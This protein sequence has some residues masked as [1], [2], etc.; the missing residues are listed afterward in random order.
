MKMI[1]KSVQCE[2]GVECMRQLNKSMDVTG[3]MCRK[4]FGYVVPMPTGSTCKDGILSKV[5]ALNESKRVHFTNINTSMLI[6][7]YLQATKKLHKYKKLKKR[8]EETQ[9]LLLAM[10]LE[11]RKLKEQ[12]PHSESPTMQLVEIQPVQSNKYDTNGYHS[13][14]VSFPS[15]RRLGNPDDDDIF[16]RVQPPVLLGDTMNFARWKR[17]PIDEM[18]DASMDT[19]NQDNDVS[20]DDCADN[21]DD[22]FEYTTA[23]IKEEHELIIEDTIQIANELFYCNI[24]DES[25][26]SCDALDSHLNE[27]DSCKSA[28]EPET[29][30]AAMDAIEPPVQVVDVTQ[31]DISSVQFGNQ[32]AN[33]V[34]IADEN[35]I[36]TMTNLPQIR[37]SHDTNTSE[38]HRSPNRHIR[39]SFCSERDRSRS[40]QRHTEP[41]DARDGV[42]PERS[43]SW[44]RRSRFEK[45]RSPS[46][47]REYSAIF[48]NFTY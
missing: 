13:V 18:A 33:I 37:I 27:S 26:D 2:L 32:F 24:C 44:D 10:Q 5:K 20:G 17:E 11:N 25:F 35:S 12:N 4:R 39:D 21:Y 19:D 43:D 30:T 41:D 7:Q 47:S 38:R 29:V 40:S 31:T 46:P 14:D 28:P 6:W 22:E 23:F 34:A 8:Y 1:E 36:P 9:K 15:P 16:A 48:I 42:G 45:R 3:K